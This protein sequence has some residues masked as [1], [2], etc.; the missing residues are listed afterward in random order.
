MPTTMMISFEAAGVETVW[1]HGRIFWHDITHFIITAMSLS[2]CPKVSCQC[3]IRH[4]RIKPGESATCI[5]L[6]GG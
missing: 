5:A 1:D 3:S 4:H 6:T 2:T